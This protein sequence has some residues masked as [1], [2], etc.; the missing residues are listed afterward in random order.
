MKIFDRLHAALSA[1]ADPNP[2]VPPGVDPA[3]FDSWIPTALRSL[4]HFDASNIKYE[5]A[6]LVEHNVIVALSPGPNGELYTT[7]AKGEHALADYL[8]GK[9]PLPEGI[10]S[11]WCNRDVAAAFRVDRSLLDRWPSASAGRPCARRSADARA[12]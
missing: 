6:R 3:R 7:V 9:A 4:D 8:T 5:A 11:V 12:L 10:V 1:F 2:D